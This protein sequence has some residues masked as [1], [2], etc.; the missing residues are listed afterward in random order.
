MSFL[1]RLATK[2]A[3]PG[4]EPDRERALADFQLREGENGLSLWEYASDTERDLAL[5][6]MA[7]ERIDRGGKI[8]KL[9]F[10]TIRRETVERFGIV[11]QT[12]GETPLQTANDKLHRE[13]QWSPSAL[14]QLAETL[15]DEQHS[16][17][18]K[19]KGDVRQLLLGL[20][21]NAV[22]STAVKETL[23]VERAK[24]KK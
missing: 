17:T 8:D 20:D 10:M 3:W 1:V 18:R 15:F 24:E 13:L 9:D 21:L 23:G 4:G 5:A 7:C 2:S 6:A 22:T 19:A 11:K 14:R 16:V 12:P